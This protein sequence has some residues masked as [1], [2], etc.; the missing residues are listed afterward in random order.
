M[1]AA[2]FVR[3]AVWA[4]AI[5]ADDVAV[6]ADFTNRGVDDSVTAGALNARRAVG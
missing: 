4:A 2:R 1:I 3:R 5:T 6:V